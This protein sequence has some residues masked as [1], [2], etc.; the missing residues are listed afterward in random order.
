MPLFNRKRASSQPPQPRGPPPS[1]SAAIAASAAFLNKSPS[2]AS[3]SSAAAAAA[4][5]SQTSSPEPI[6]SIQTKRMVRRGSQS[7]TGSGAIMGGNPRNSMVRQTSNSS[8]SDRTFRSPSPG[9]RRQD[10]VSPAPDAPPVP[11]IPKNLVKTQRRAAS[12]DV[13]NR[14]SLPSPSTPRSAQRN[15]SVDR[16]GRQLNLPRM[17]ELKREDSNGVNYSRPMSPARAISPPPRPNS[18]VG[19]FTSPKV[20]NGTPRGNPVPAR[21]Q[22]ALDFSSPAAKKIQQDVQ[23][24]ANAPVKKNKKPVTEGA[25]LANGTMNTAPT[26]SAMRTAPPEPVQAQSQLSQADTTPKKKKRTTVVPPVD[27]QASDGASLTPVNPSPSTVSSASPSS[28]RA[29]G[30]ILHKQP[31]VVREDPEAEATAEVQSTPQTTPKA[32]PKKHNFMKSLRDTPA[33]ITTSE[34]AVQAYVAPGGTRPRAVSLDVPRGNGQRA[35]SSSPSRNVHAHF[36]E[37]SSLATPL[38]VRHQPPPRSISPM[39]SALRQSPASSVRNISPNVGI[40][41]GPRAPPSDTSDTM[42]MTSQDGIKQTKRKKSVRISEDGSVPV[43]PAADPNGRRE[44]SGSWANDD[45]NEIMKPRSALPSFSSV[46]GRKQQQAEVPEK[47]TETVS[48]SMNNSA[49]TLPDHREASNDDLVGAVLAQHYAQKGKQAETQAPVSSE[50]LPPQV[51]SKETSADMSDSAYSEDEGE[52]QAQPFQAE[53]ALAND[54]KTSSSLAAEP[55]NHRVEAP[56]ANPIE[57]AVPDLAIQPPTPGVEEEPEPSLEAVTVQRPVLKQRNSMPGAWDEWEESKTAGPSR[58]AIRDEALMSENDSSDED[59]DVTLQPAQTSVDG[60]SPIL[61]PIYESDSD[62][63]EDFADAEEDL[64]EL[65]HGG[66]ASLDAIVESPVTKPAAVIPSP[67]V[68]PA[69]ALPP[70]RA[71]PEASTLTEEQLMN[72]NTDWNS[73]TAYWSSLSRKKKLELEAEAEAAITV[74]V[75]ESAPKPK[76][77]K[78]SVDQLDITNPTTFAPAPVSPRDDPFEPEEEEQP[79][80]PALRKSMRDSGESERTSGETQMRKSMRGPPPQAAPSSSSSNETHMRTSMRTGGSARSDGGSMRTSMRGDAGSKP[81]SKR[82]SGPPAPANIPGAGSAA[83]AAA[84]LQPAQKPTKPVV[85]PLPAY[86]SD[87]ESSFRKNKRRG[88]VSTVDSVGKY[89]MKR[90][91]RSGSVDAGPPPPPA[92]RGRQVASH[93]KAGSG[94]FSLRSLSP[95]GSFMGRNNGE[96]LRQSL[97]GAPVDNTPT[98]RGKNN[99]AS[100]DAKASSGFGMSGF[101]KSKP[102]PAPAPKKSS[103]GFRSRFADSDDEDDAPRGGFRS[104]FADSDEEDS[105]VGPPKQM[106]SNLA[107]VRGIPK[108]RGQDSDSTDLSDSEDEARTGTKKAVAGRA[109]TKPAVPSQSDIDAAMEIAKRNVA[110]MNGGR[111]PGVPQPPPV[112]ASPSAPRQEVPLTPTRRKGFLGSVLRRNSSSVV[113]TSPVDS[114]HP[115]TPTLRSPAKQPKL[116]RRTTPQ[117]WPLPATPNDDAAAETRPTTS[118]GVPAMK[119]TMR[120]DMNRRSMSGNDL[121][122]MANGGTVASTATKKK[123]FSGL[124]K[125]FGLND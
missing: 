13:P 45:I 44:L 32:A 25:R 73:A 67:P 89:T 112:P 4:L 2:T 37:G 116:Q 62:V 90:S 23:N 16:S 40:N 7:S 115:L 21:P 26:G 84:K 79:R 118:D 93:A 54:E 121:N 65:G 6:G 47:V 80:A 69:V 71:M 66:F 75:V 109:S 105:P 49:S 20:S 56:E 78:Q 117:N 124:R 63:S 59:E 87:S 8:M 52:L 95:T 125:L 110:A 119:K 55:S 77:K 39:K 48:S 86:D 57:L 60:H 92:E 88:S 9:G 99:R 107:P 58:Q 85:A 102:A 106:P 50:P 33:T 70:S 35:S 11:A 101:G 103:G 15:T 53:K 46:R 122:R 111:E 10:A 123:K 28:P 41:G 29:A 42:S 27:T 61:Q 43:P 18:S 81:A 120:P 5:R 68:S 51:T 22:S 14:I 76:K 24:A 72:D 36:V 17:P 96:Q 74:P 94:R 114:Q 34:G 98:M 3:L 82:V 91:M 97:R 1:S 38:S 113:P 64:S 100:R 19:W 31:S 108:R 30:G 104:R 12:L 83:A